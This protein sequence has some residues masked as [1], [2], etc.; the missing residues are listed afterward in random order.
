MKPED[1]HHEDP[2]RNEHT[3]SEQTMTNH[4]SHPTRGDAQADAWDDARLEAALRQIARD[5]EPA[6]D[7]PAAFEAALLAERRAA[8]QPDARQLWFRHNGWAVAACIALLLIGFAAVA[9]LPTMG[10]ARSVAIETGQAPSVGQAESMPLDLLNDQPTRSAVQSLGDAD[11]RERSG[12][13]KPTPRRRSMGQ[14]A[15][16][17]AGSVAK[18]D[19]SLFEFRSTVPPDPSAATT[20]TA[21]PRLVIRD[22]AMTLKVA[23]LDAAIEGLRMVVRAE[24]GEFVES[25]RRNTPNE[26]VL[27]LKLESARM[28]GVV[29]EITA[30]GEVTAEQVSGRDVTDQAIDLEA[31]IRNAE[32]VEQELLDLLERRDDQPLRDVL[33]LQR[34]LGNARQQVERLVAQRDGL[35][36]MA[37]LATL[38]V[39][40]FVEPEPEPEPEEPDEGF[41]TGITQAWND[42]LAGALATLELLIRIAVGGIVLWLLLGAAAVLLWSAQQRRAGYAV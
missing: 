14:G 8:R 3:P 7:E 37:T 26:A 15:A 25:L 35:I 33:E 31:R 20:A 32:R 2:A 22:G 19:A 24:R 4:D 39:T 29:E 28:L 17:S 21:A 6:S 16:E 40:V 36:R 42:G 38:R 1:N 23:E 11:A 34:E 18:S 13:M 5:S 30:L 9:I 27:V 41:L 10:R 12:P